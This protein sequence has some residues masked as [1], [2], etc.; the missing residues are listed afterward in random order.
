MA[1]RDLIETEGFVAAK[2]LRNLQDP[3]IVMT[4]GAQRLRSRTVGVRH[5]NAERIC[6][7]P[8][9]DMHMHASYT[10]LP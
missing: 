6:A 9:L 8:S 3:Y 5:K 10:R 1:A 7:A 4:V 2:M